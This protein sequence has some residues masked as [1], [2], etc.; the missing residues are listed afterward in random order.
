MWKVN[1]Q[2]FFPL[3]FKQKGNME[4]KQRQI[5]QEFTVHSGRVTVLKNLF[6]I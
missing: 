1:V 6:C 5:G 3:G 2:R 4:K